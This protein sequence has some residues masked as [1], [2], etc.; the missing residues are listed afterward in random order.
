MRNCLVLKVTLLV[1]LICGA[2]TP[3]LAASATSQQTSTRNVEPEQVN[4]GDRITVYEKSGQVLELIVEESITTNQPALDTGL[5]GTWVSDITDNSNRYFKKKNHK[6]LV[7]TFEQSGERIVGKVSSLT[8]GYIEGVREGDTIKFFFRSLKIS[9]YEITGEWKVSADGYEMEG[10]W[11]HPTYL[12][13]GKWNLTRLDPV[14]AT[15]HAEPPMIKGRLVLDQSAVEV[16]LADIDKI[17]VRHVVSNTEESPA[18][19]CQ[20]SEATRDAI[21]RATDAAFSG[22]QVDLEV[23]AL[24]DEAEKAAGQPECD[25]VRAESLANEANVLATASAT[26]KDDFDDSPATPDSKP[27]PSKSSKS[28]DS[29]I[30]TA[31][32]KCAVGVAMYGLIPIIAGAAELGILTTVAG[33]VLCVPA[34][35]IGVSMV[36]S[37]EASTEASSRKDQAAYRKTEQHR[38]F[39]LTRENLARDM[40]RGGGEYLTAMAYLEGCPVEVHDSFAKMTQRNFKQIIPQAE[41]D[42][43]DMLHNLELQIA[44]DPLLVA[45]CSSVS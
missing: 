11:K 21:D 45:K 28:F 15:R 43:E 1:F 32:G 4:P 14:V 3:T 13:S 41:M 40:A 7:V 12:S 34:A 18:L 44:K 26:V 29:E 9:H 5:T 23:L 37:G 35:G 17:E 30:D 19:A 31:Y 20:M 2:S 42:A 39:A 8:D 38:F 36:L 16:L 10:S 25:N 27:G 6:K 22:N 24:L 33:T